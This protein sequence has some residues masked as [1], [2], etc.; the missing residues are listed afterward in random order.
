MTHSLL[1]D[2]DSQALL[3]ASMISDIQSQVDAGVTIGASSLSDISSRVNVEALDVVA[4]DTI[5]EITGIADVPATPTMR[6][7]LMLLYQWL[8]NNTQVTSTER[9]ILNDAG[10]EVLDATMADD[11][12]VFTQGKL[13]AA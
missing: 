8:R 2:L 12:T 13:T 3:N 9:R 11:G 1:S 4:T 10:T 7:A 6:Q 5:A